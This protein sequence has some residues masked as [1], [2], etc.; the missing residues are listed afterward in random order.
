M[1][2]IKWVVGTSAQYEA[3]LE[4]DANSLYFLEDTQEIYKGDKSFTQSVVLLE[5]DTFPPKGAQGKVYIGGT[6]LEGKVWDGET[7]K[8][9]IQP[10]A[11]TLTDSG[12]ENKAVSG[13]A[14]K[15]Y[16]KK[17]VSEAVTGNFVDGITYDK[18]TKELS[19][20][21]GGAPQKVAIE[22]FVTGA[23]YAGD[24][25]VLSFTVQGGEKISVNLPKENF[26]K[27][28]TYNKESKEI[29]LTLTDNSQVKIPAGDLVDINEFESTQSVQLTVS[30]A[31][32]VSANV[33]VS[34][35]GG[36][37]LQSKANG[38]YVAAPNVDGK[39]DKVAGEKADEIIVA[40][41]D[42]TVKVSGKKAGGAA[43]AGDP[44]EN[45]LATEKAVAAVKAA[46]EGS[47]NTKF[48]K[49]DIVT[50]VGASGSASDVKVASE[51][52]VATAIE[53]VKNGKIDKSSITTTVVESSNSA[54]KVVSESAVVS[55]MS[56]VVLTEPEPEPV[57]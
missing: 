28:G 14:V 22:G 48:N 52:A 13:E 45:T 47:I 53:Q 43:L 56:W 11:T 40:K 41:A 35:D 34:G 23:S 1:A 39:L 46:L 27:S 54:T 26:V 12:T 7:W 15:T 10:I 17:K 37:L 21:K 19:Y 5:D 36:N 57:P 44:N 50:A 32:V 31:G 49:S 30:P 24:T 25:G 33:K 4:K 51:K 2:M 16:V 9:V 20:T 42:G 6:T 55:A 3:V 18:S 8:T 29:I 38:L